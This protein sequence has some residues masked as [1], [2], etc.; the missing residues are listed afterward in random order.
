MILAL[1]IISIASVSA[2]DVSDINNNQDYIS[3]DDSVNE[4]LLGDYDNDNLALDD[5]FDLTDDSD[6]ESNQDIPSSK[7]GE[8]GS[9]DSSEGESTD[10]NPKTTTIVSKTTKVVNGDVYSVTLKDG[11]GAPLSDK[12]LIFTFNGKNYTRTTDSNGLASLSINAKA[13]KYLISVIFEG[14]DSYGGSS[15]SNNITVSKTP[16][17]IANSS[18]SAVNGK[19]YSVVLKDKNGKVLSSKK[20]TLKFN[21]KTYTVTTNSKGVASITISGTVAKTYA[22]TYKFAGDDYY[23]ASSGSKNLTVKMG[24]KFVGSDARI[25]KGGKFNVTLKNSNN[26]VLANK[27]VTVY[28]NGKVWNKT[29]NSKGIVVLTLNPTPAKTYNITYK[30]AGSSYYGASS[31][32]LSVYIKT[33]TSLTNSGS[34]VA[35]GTPYYITLKNYKGTVLVNKTVTLT[36]RGKTYKKTTNSKGQVSLK[37]TSGLNNTYT[38]GYKYSGTNYYGPS[39]GSVKIKVKKATSLTGPASTIIIK[40][41]AYKVTLKDS[42]GKV[43]SG[44]KITFTFNGKTYNKTTNS[45]GVANLTIT[46]AAGKTYKLS[47][48]FPGTSYYNRTASGTINL[49]V[50]IK[51]TFKNSGSSIMNGTIYNL[52]LKDTDG[53]LLA[54]KLVNLTFDGKTYQNQTDANGTVGLFIN[55]TGPKVTK[56]TY[57]FEGD[58]TYEP[59]S[60]SVSLDVKSDKIFKLAHIVNAS[61]WLRSYVEKNHKLPSTITV[62]GV[63]IN[64]TVFAYLMGKAVVNIDKNKTSNIAVVDVNS[65]YKNSGDTSINVA[66]NKE[67]YLNV[68]KVLTDFVETNGRLAYWITTNVTNGTNVTKVKTS[69]NLYIFGLAK[70]LDFYS[71]M[72]RLPNYVT[73]NTKDVD[74]NSSVTKK[75]NSSQYKKGLNEVQALNSTELAKYLQS[76]GNDALNAAIRELANNLT[77]G[78]ATVWDKANAIFKWVRD[79]VDYEYYANTKYKATG[80]LSKKRGNC[81]DHA[82]LIV[83]LC[84]AADIPARYSHGKN[85]KFSSGLNTGHVWAQIYV[86]GVWYSADATSSRNELGNIHNWNTNSFTLQEYALVHLPF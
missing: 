43:L 21:G 59:S 19:S 18:S 67:G 74:S 56:L 52:T 24:T 62:N 73:L 70:C 32:T 49:A 45:K 26:K 80:T 25:V 71:N 28:Y 50:K 83:A 16:T 76:S 35:Q 58:N 81:C 46:S 10:S 8:K 20:V 23:A 29:S 33:P 6:E 17:T 78:K 86:D 30:Y 47:Y 65:Y 53:K 75:G 5:D 82:N 44:Q 37:I 42:D 54:N 77:K 68:S 14:D 7:L 79:N 85:C 48:K 13:A 9:L 3:A 63:K 38:M 11:D 51:T 66:L 60:G 39:S 22:L 2:S 57:K 84:R 72:N 64:I 34:S 27:K 1:F 40:G 41:N 55:C 31:K 36:Y 4:N 69:P 12:N 61:V 15:I